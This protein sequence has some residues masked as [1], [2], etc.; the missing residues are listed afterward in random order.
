MHRRIAIAVLGVTS[1]LAGLMGTAPAAVAATATAPSAPTG[2]MAVPGDTSAVLSWTAPASNGGSA[3]T[4]YNVYEGT[5]SG[6]ENYSTPV[7]GGT[8]IAGTTTTVTGLTN[9][10]SYYFTVEAVNAIGSSP[11]SNEA[12]AVPA[13]TV[14]SAPTNVVAVGGDVSATVTWTAPSNQGGSNISGYTVTSLDSTASTRG[15]QTCTWTT[16]P[17]TCTLVGLTNGDSY[18]FSV[19]ATNSLGTGIASDASNAVVPAITVPSAPTQLSATP[20]NTTVALELDRTFERRGSHHG[21]QHL[22]GHHPGRRELL[23][24]GQ[25]RSHH[26]Y[27]CDGNEPHQR[28]D[29]LLHRQGRELRR[30]LCSLERGMG[31]PRRDGPEHPDGGERHR[32]LRVRNR[33]LERTIEH[34]WID[35]HALQR[36]SD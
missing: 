17:L 24:A 8:L 7:N 26:G 3:I 27:D 20:G 1:L 12:F 16:G 22:R 30:V 35:H 4:G 29:V 28:H 9:A 5:T 33:D 36:H 21:L 14:P 15:G 11:A 32:R 25:R 19:T 13:A 6:G 34:R 10:H 18:T 23:D 2:L 31:H